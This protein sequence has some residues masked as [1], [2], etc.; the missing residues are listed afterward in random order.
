MTIL[1]SLRSKSGCQPS[2]AAP[3]RFYS[4]VRGERWTA[5]AFRRPFAVPNLCGISLYSPPLDKFGNS[6]RGVAFC[7]E[8]VERCALHNYD[9]LIMHADEQPKIDPRK[10][11]GEHEK[12]DTIAMLFAA[13]ANDLNALRRLYLRDADFNAADYDRRTVSDGL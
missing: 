2:R 7:K 13:R 12:E 1:A 8:L 5:L 6:T 11:V 10:R 9:S 3:A 4:S